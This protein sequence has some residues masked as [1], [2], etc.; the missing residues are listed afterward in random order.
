MAMGT[1]DISI[2]STSPCGEERAH[3]LAATNDPCVSIGKLPKLPRKR[4]KIVDGS[5]LQLAEPMYY[6]S[7]R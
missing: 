3:N 2:L 7:M 1:I 6:R 5:R 4:S